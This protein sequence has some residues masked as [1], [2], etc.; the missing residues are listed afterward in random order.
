MRTD[1]VIRNTALAAL[2]NL[3][4]PDV[5]HPVHAVLAAALRPKTDD[6][7][8]R[9]AIV[10]PTL[11]LARYNVKRLD[12]IEAALADGKTDAPKRRRLE[13]EAA[14]LRLTIRFAIDVSSEPSEFYQ[15]QLVEDIDP[16][17]SYRRA[18]ELIGV[19]PE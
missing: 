2:W 7:D 11:R 19:W 12:A 18:M 14:L 5:D 6:F 1:L 4:G 15:Q 17:M 9:D 8:P 10:E 13:A 3:F 16:S